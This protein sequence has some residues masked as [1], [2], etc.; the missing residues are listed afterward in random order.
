MGAKN[1]H[2]IINP[3]SGKGN[4]QLTSELV[5]SVLPHD[6]FDVKITEPNV[7]IMAVQGPKSFKLME[8]V[9]GKK[10]KDLDISRT[11]TIGG[12]IRGNEGVIALGDF[13]IIGQIKQGFYR[14]KKM[15]LAQGSLER[16][17]NAV[18]Q[19]SKRIKTETEIPRRMTRNSTT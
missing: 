3:I 15:G 7:D 13:E 17:T 8:K 5:S 9:L 18:I 1:I 4:N 12:V 10:I 16:L 14:S 19:S 6:K 2:F 11:A